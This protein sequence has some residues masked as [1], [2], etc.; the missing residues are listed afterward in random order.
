MSVDFDLS[1]GK[2]SSAA[3]EGI[4]PVSAKKT[5]GQW[6]GPGAVRRGGVIAVG[7]GR[8]GSATLGCWRVAGI[9]GDFAMSDLLLDDEPRGSRSRTRR[10][11]ACAGSW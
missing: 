4:A 2:V 9:F 8:V 6:Q 10:G 3:A 1:D 11:H 7:M 5:V